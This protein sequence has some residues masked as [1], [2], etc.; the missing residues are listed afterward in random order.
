MR[1]EFRHQ[2][3]RDDIAA[4]LAMVGPYQVDDDDRQLTIARSS[5]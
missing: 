1:L 2:V 3:A 5:R 4:L